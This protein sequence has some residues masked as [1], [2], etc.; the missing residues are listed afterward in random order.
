MKNKFLKKKLTAKNK[1]ENATNV[2][3]KTT[4]RHPVGQLF[5]AHFVV[6]KE[7]ERGK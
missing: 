6:N 4:S 5:L 1:Y 2:Y 3:T 7:I